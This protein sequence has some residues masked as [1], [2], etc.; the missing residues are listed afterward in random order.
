M[1]FI[2][3][4]LCIG[5][6]HSRQP[7]CFYFH[8][9]TTFTP[10][11]LHRP[12][13]ALKRHRQSED[14]II[15]T[16]H[17]KQT[18]DPAAHLICNKTERCVSWH[19]TD[20]Q[21]KIKPAGHRYSVLN[22]H[23]PYGQV[24]LSL[25]D[26]FHAASRKCPWKFLVNMEPD[27]IMLHPLPES[28]LG[29]YVAH[30]LTFN[31]FPKGLSELLGGSEASPLI[32]SFTCGTIFSSSAGARAFSAQTSSSVVNLTAAEMPIYHQD[33]WLSALMRHA[34]FAPRFER[35]VNE[36]REDGWHADKQYT[37]VHGEKQHYPS[38]RK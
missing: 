29:D 34:G 18:P 3:M 13:N 25:S 37:F 28:L 2:L 15:I 11:H 35:H 7:V 17:G 33:I 32:Y 19:A 23:L 24:Q 1:L 30:R 10:A 6:A 36:N 38:S 9:P 16:T 5:V 20:L 8:L 31:T 27:C 14:N 4:S 21:L 26:I 12:I 22:R